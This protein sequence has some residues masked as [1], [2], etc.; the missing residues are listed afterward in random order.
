MATVYLAKDL[1][2]ERKVALNVLKPELAM[3]TMFLKRNS[4]SVTKWKASSK[5]FQRA[6]GRPSRGRSWLARSGL[7]RPIPEWGGAEQPLMGF[8]Q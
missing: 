4:C 5:R 6:R 2:H 8:V 3:S 7:T 1:K